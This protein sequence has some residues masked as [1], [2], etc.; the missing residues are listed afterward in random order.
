MWHA[1][2]VLGRLRQGDFEFEIGICYIIRFFLLNKQTKNS[3][4]EK[5]KK[6]REREGGERGGRRDGERRR[7]ILM[8]TF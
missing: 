6:G 7:N 3:R 2:S 8:L 1:A 5:Q 4:W